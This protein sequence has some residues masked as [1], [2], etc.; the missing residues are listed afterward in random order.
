M[1][2]LIVTEKKLWAAVFAAYYLTLTTFLTASFFPQYRLWGLNHWAYFPDSVPVILF[3]VGAILPLVA[4]QLSRRKLR[5]NYTIATVLAILVMAV[6]FYFMRD[7]THFEGDG[8]QV[9]TLL[10]EES[11]VVKL[12]NFGET[13]I[14]RAL[15]NIIGGGGADQALITYQSLSCLAGLG[16]CLFIAYAS[17]RLFEGTTDRALFLLG[18]ISGGYMLLFCGHVENYSFFVASV[19]VFALTGLMA[20]GGR[21]SKWFVL[22][23]LLLAIFFHVFGVSL[24]PA[25]FYLLVNDT[26]GWRQLSHRGPVF[27]TTMVLVAAVVALALLWYFYNV[28]HYFR[29]ALVPLWK[30]R[31]TVD[32]YTFFAPKHL[33]DIVNLI[34]FSLPAMLLILIVIL[35]TPGRK[36]FRNPA[37]TFLLV[38]VLSTVAVAAIFN[39][40]LGMPRDWDLFSFVGIPLVVGGYYLLIKNARRVR[41]YPAIVS[42]AVAL[43]F[44]SLVP[45][46]VG[47]T[48][49]QIATSRA[50]DSAMLDM[51]RNIF[52]LLK[53]HDYFWKRGDYERSP[54]LYFE[55]ERHYPEWEM[56]QTGLR[57][58]EQGRTDQAMAAFRG[59]IKHN[60]LMASA[61][62]NLGSCHLAQG[63]PDSAI[64]NLEIAEGLNRYDPQIWR[65]LGMAYLAERQY[66]RAEESFTKSIA[67]DPDDMQTYAGLLQTY[68]LGGATREYLDLLYQ[69]ASRP[70]A[71]YFVFQ[72]LGDHFVSRGSYSHAAAQYR[73]ALAKGMPEQEYELIRQRYP[74]MGL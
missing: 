37:H 53:M 33:A 49:V 68:Q 66:G 3:G 28:S 58:R 41:Y 9:L 56:V 63:H 51:K 43:G 74:Q 70:D 26:K 6:L 47:Q 46:A 40:R 27:K 69:L 23:P 4:Y 42:M 55:W 45:R 21:I 73:T 15:Y 57:L 34:L 38:M 16:L 67:L 62:L 32:G 44:L 17:R 59:A 61:Y 2:N 30:N 24:A 11:P 5:L 36:S 7:R 19:G 8:Y 54:L 14:H 12:S 64:A 13:L 29:L 22:P 1:N 50:F 48:S 60:P 18:M 52:M 65:E 25:A 20:S 31:F 35:L 39:P 10:A 71:P 72:K